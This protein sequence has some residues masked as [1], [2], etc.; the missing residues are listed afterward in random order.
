MRC[1]TILYS[2]TLTHDVVA[3]MYLN[4]LPIFKSVV[5]GPKSFTAGANEWLLP[6]ENTVAFEIHRV[7]PASVPADIRQHEPEPRSSAR[8]TPQQVSRLLSTEPITLMLYVVTDPDTVP[9]TIETHELWSFPKLLRELPRE[10]R[11][12]PLYYEAPFR[13]DF[14]LPLRAFATAPPVPFGCRG[15]PELLQAV[16]EL[17]DALTRRDLAKLL[18]LWSLSFE[19]EERAY[20]GPEGPK[21]AELRQVYEELCQLEFTVA[22]LDPGTL[23]FSARAHGRVAHVTRTNGA[24]VIEGTVPVTVEGAEEGRLRAN[25]LLTQVQGR[26]R[27][28]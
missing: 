12:V 4:D 11:S 19:E 27:L 1:P 26:W 10:R 17:H 18:D 7:R 28:M 25:L 21:A 15:T 6:G 24:P 8:P 3:Q 13:V 23:H 14:E 5:R 20:A 9:A 16:A 2:A 22:P